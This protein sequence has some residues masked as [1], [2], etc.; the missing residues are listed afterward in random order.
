VLAYVIEVLDLYAESDAAISDFRAVFS[1]RILPE[2][3]KAT[4]FALGPA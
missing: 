2:C 4:W 1:A 3:H